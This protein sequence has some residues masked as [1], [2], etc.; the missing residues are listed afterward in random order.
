M[1]MSD[2]DHDQG[3]YAGNMPTMPRGQGLIGVFARHRVAANMLMAMMILSGIIA[4]KLL[5]IQFFPS[6]EP[7]LITVTTTWSGAST[8]DIESAITTPLEQRL[9][10]VEDIK[11]ITSTSVSGVSAITLELETGADL[12]LTMDRV[13]REID[14]YSNLPQD[15]EDTEVKTGGHFETV[16]R[17]LLSGDV[18]LSELR[19]LA[20][21]FEEDLLSRG[22]DRIDF[23]GM[24]SEDIQITLEPGK[25]EELGLSLNQ[26]AD[27]I[28]Q[29]SQD[30]P[31]GLVGKDDSTRELRSLGKRRDPAD[32]ADIPLVSFEQGQI[33]LGSIADIQRSSR[34]REAY[35]TIQDK[36][37]IVI[38]LQRSENGNSLEAARVLQ[39]WK[40][41]ILT[42]LPPN[43]EVQVFNERWTLI[44]GRI[45]LMLKNGGGGLVL[46]L[47]ILFLFLS[48]RVAFWV[49]V[50]IPVS[51]MATLAV[52]YLA[53]SSIN[54][55]SLFA[56][57]MALGI[58][59][60]DAIVV[61]EDAQAHYE[62]GEDGAQAAE[63]GARR[64]LAPVMASSLTTIAAFLPLMLVGGWMGRIMFA[65][66]LSLIH[67]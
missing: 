4:L 7:T 49:A 5:N 25:L 67:I 38:S 1:A 13:Q 15:A 31:A 54:M 33:E 42:T 27:K 61:A 24:P 10:S 6:G 40:D 58:I 53:G 23:I 3:V 22:I 16:A 41:D 29:V 48:G 63:G 45:D 60:D 14:S 19:A 18:E 43:M 20:Y 65:I 8:E 26:V 36:P 17:V 9:R 12:I 46:V 59:V 55:I 39:G 50:G 44:K 56:L 28:R 11:Q 30:Q 2:G 51:F 66:P 34:Q 35:V 47:M 37:A 32:F 57:I 62:M 52:M 21:R 64:M